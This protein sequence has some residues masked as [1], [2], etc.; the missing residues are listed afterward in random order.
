MQAFPPTVVFRHRK[1][2]LKKCSLRG[3]EEREDFRFYTYPL[4]GRPK[5][6]GYVLLDMNA[7]ELTK[8]DSHRGLF[9][10][11]ATWR[12]A[13]KMMQVDSFD[14]MERRSLPGIFRT[15]Y[16]RRQ[17]DCSDPE[18]GLASIEALYVAYRILGRDALSLLDHYYWREEFLTMNEACF[19][20]GNF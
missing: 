19:S 8:A 6:P 14:E 3:L 4:Q 16:R 5:L 13:E 9:V 20:N 1:E 17:E 11:D 7:K 15:A 10:L 18:R 2:N 12:Y